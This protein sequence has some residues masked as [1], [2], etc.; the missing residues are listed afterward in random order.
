MRIGNAEQFALDVDWIDLGDSAERFAPADVATWSSLKIYVAGRLLTANVDSGGKYA[1][2]VF[3]SP[4]PLCT[5]FLTHLDSLI[6]K[7]T[8]PTRSGPDDPFAYL[9]QMWG[10]LENQDSEES[11]ILAEDVRTWW[12]SHNIRGGRDGMA[13][14]DLLF[15]R[16]G[17]WMYAWWRADPE[18]FAS[19]N[20]RFVPGEG[21][22]RL[23]IS[24]IADA[25]LELCG[26]VEE[27]LNSQGVGTD[28]DWRVGEFLDLHHT[29]WSER[30]RFLSV[31]TESGLDAARFSLATGISEENVAAIIE[32]ASPTKNNWERVIGA[33]DLPVQDSVPTLHETMVGSGVL[34]LFRSAAPVLTRD[35]VSALMALI[36]FSRE[37]SSSTSIEGLRVLREN[38]RDDLRVSDNKR[39]LA[40][41]AIGQSRARIVRDILGIEPRD[42]VDIEQIVKE[43][44]GSTEV[45]ECDLSDNS[46]DGVSLWS[47]TIGPLVAVNRRSRKA[48]TSWGRRMTLA[49]ELCHIV[50]D[51]AGGRSL[52]IASG[53]PWAPLVLERVANAFAAEFV[54]PR[55]ALEPFDGRFEQDEE[56]CRL[57]DRYQVGAT[58][59]AHQLRNHGFISSSSAEYYIS[60]YASRRGWDAA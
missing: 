16:Q 12:V 23:S 53:T 44:L 21:Q 2:Q 51:S 22:T 9:E 20:V 57:M 28:D 19:A 55:A 29:V 14:P 34:A 56:F 33:F 52:G 1:E 46:I 4:L 47:E 40:A 42:P 24:A 26:I 58:V 59:A 7:E 31:L 54:L 43:L 39:A 18:P 13:L 3:G 17:S 60:T 32:G 41:Y 50:F 27:R 10:V 45:M 8:R 38:L 36:S 6:A 11:D 25:L 30:S 5:W 48:Q 49:H 15:W 37:R 35:D